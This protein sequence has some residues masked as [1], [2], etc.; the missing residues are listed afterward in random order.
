MQ[1]QNLLKLVQVS[2]GKNGSKTVTIPFEMFHHLVESALRAK[3]EFD[4]GFYLAANP[5]I[6]AAVKKKDIAS[7][8]E[9]YYHSGYFEGRMP[10]RFEVDE[11]FYLEQN[12]DVAKAIK[13][14]RIKS[15]QL[16]FD[17]NGFREGRAPY[18]GFSLF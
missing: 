11:E 17:T 13:A 18:K 14:R 8:A 3:G 2:E 1:Y 9:H 6:R 5:D 10:K 7:A 16:H 4:E 12:P 15:C